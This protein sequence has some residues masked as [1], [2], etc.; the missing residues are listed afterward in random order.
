MRAE[1]YVSAE[2]AGAG[3]TRLVRLSGAPPLVVR[4]TG[5]ARV[6]LVGAAAGPLAGDE[7]VLHLQVGPGAELVVAQAAGTVALGS[8]GPGR[9]WSQ[10]RI[11]ASVGA[12][13]VLVVAGA[14]LVAAAGSRHRV[15]ADVDLGEGARL[16]W[17]DLVVPGRSGEGSGRLATRLRVTQGGAALLDHQL[18]LGR[19][20]TGWQG[21]A[22]LAGARCVGSLAVL[23]LAHPVPAGRGWGPGAALMAL[24][25]PGGVLGTAL[26]PAHEV[27][28]TLAEMAADV[29]GGDPALAGLLEQ[30]R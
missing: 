27:G 12:G 2:L 14:A 6:H 5:P 9:P 25:A 22:V 7:T 28:R 15:R 23:G 19:P 20:G 24:G 3:Q 26:G 21:P 29:L 13:G 8:P 10:H 16:V 4:P 11:Q 30:L 1:A 17:R 18:E